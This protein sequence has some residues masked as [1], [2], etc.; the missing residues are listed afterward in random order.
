LYFLL[1]VFLHPLHYHLT[2]IHLLLPSHPPTMRFATSL[3]ALAGLTAAIAAPAPVA[4]KQRLRQ[5]KRADLSPTDLLDSITSELTSTTQAIN[6][7]ASDVVSALA[8]TTTVVTGGLLGSLLGGL[9][10]TS[11]TASTVNLTAVTSL[12]DSIVSEVE[13]LQTTLEG[14]AETGVTVA[15]DLSTGD[16]TDALAALVAEVESV[17]STVTSAASSVSG[18]SAIASSFESSGEPPPS[19][20]LCCV[21][22]PQPLC[23]DPLTHQPSFS[24]SALSQR[25]PVCRH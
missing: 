22:L 3:V 14:L 13:G 12:L 6:A 23:A 9:L 5:A 11:S 20:P 2:S 24:F 4:S 15:E 1:F 17:V 10:G 16:A 8:A 7:T 21:F 19:I 25:P 18:L